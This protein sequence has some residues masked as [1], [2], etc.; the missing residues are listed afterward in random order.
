MS[1]VPCADENGVERAVS[2]NSFDFACSVGAAIFVETRARP[3]FIHVC[4]CDYSQTLHPA[5]EVAVKLASSAAAN[6]SSRNLFSHVADPLFLPG[7]LALLA[8]ESDCV[9]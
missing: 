9:P 1:V 8:H 4:V 3:A 2:Q 7:A 5:A 6:Q